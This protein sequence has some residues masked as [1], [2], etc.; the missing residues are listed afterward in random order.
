[1]AQALFD[2]SGLPEVIQNSRTCQYCN[3]STECMIYH[4]INE[5]GTVDSSGVGDIFTDATDHLTPS[6]QAFLQKWNKMI[7]YEED[8][9]SIFRKEIWTMLSK[10]REEIGRFG[11][12]F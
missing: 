7:A 2:Q 4:K 9:V 3:V 1:L 6:H 8:D 11:L 5:Q 10:D 12:T